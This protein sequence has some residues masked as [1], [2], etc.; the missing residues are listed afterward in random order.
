MAFYAY[1]QAN[2]DNVIGEIVGEALYRAHRSRGMAVRYTQGSLLN[3][4]VIPPDV[5]EIVEKWENG[6]RLNYKEFQM[7]QRDTRIRDH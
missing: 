7:L 1:D 5:E 3:Y 4:E 2:S 6:D